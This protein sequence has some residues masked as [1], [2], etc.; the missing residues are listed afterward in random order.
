MHEDK[1]TENWNNEYTAQFIDTM[2]CRFSPL[3]F[4]SNTKNILP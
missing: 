3:S 1:K 4:A 2:H